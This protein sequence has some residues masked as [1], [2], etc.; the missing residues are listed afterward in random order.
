MKGENTTGSGESAKLQ[1]R[2]WPVM[3]FVKDQLSRKQRRRLWKRTA[4]VA[5]TWN[6]EGITPKKQDL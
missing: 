3:L 1:V 5:M 4:E 6:S 2:G